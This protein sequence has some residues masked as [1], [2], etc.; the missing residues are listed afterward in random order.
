MKGHSHST[1]ALTRLLLLP[2][3]MKPLFAPLID[4]VNVF[5]FNS[6]PPPPPPPLHHHHLAQYLIRIVRVEKRIYANLMCVCGLVC[7]ID[8]YGRIALIWL[9]RHW[10]DRGNYGE[11]VGLLVHLMRTQLLTYLFARAQTI[12]AMVKCTMVPIVHPSFDPFWPFQTECCIWVM[13]VR[14]WIE[15]TCRTHTLVGRTLLD[16]IIVYNIYIVDG[17][18]TSFFPQKYFN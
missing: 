12:T 1:V 16:P 15:S 6:S 10:T 17:K 8:T 11:R 14:I 4:T 7:N 9:Q 3:L 2:W 5:L 18:W 13:T